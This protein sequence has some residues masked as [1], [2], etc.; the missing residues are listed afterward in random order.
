MAS[1][2][3]SIDLTLLGELVRKHPQLVREVTMKD[4]SVHKYLS[5]NIN[6]KQQPDK[7]GHTAYIKA[8]CKREQQLQGLNYYLCDLK[9]SKQ[10]GQQAAQQQQQ[11]AATAND[12]GELPF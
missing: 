8:S 10:Q 12:D 5:I 6:E 11:Q 2:Y 1:Y 4:G 7:Y 3:G 9:E